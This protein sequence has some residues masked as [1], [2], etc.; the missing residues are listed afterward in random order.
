MPRLNKDE[1]F[2]NIADLWIKEKEKNKEL[3]EENANLRGEID[4]ALD[5]ILEYG[6]IDGG[7]HK[8]WVLDQ[9]VRILTGEN[10]GKWVKKY[11]DGEHGSETYLWDE[12]IAP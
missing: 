11:Q 1:Q 2:N 6:G 5:L 3:K 7:H 9:V 4:K 12:G 10:Y 8:M